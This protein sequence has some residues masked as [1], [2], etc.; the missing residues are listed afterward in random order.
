M[1][2][3]TIQHFDPIIRSKLLQAKTFRK[4][5]PGLDILGGRLREVQLYRDQVI[6]K[7]VYSNS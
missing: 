1:C 5:P 6:Y 3:V 4:Q 2:A 7:H